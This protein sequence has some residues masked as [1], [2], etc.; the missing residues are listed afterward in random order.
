MFYQKLLALRHS[1]TAL[2]D[3]DYIALNENDP[4]VM[5]YMRGYKDQVVLVV[6]N[7]SAEPQTA[8]FNLSAQGVSS[9]KAATLLTTLS[10]LSSEADIDQIKLEPFSVYIGQVTATSK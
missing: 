3:G 5:S 9:H 1:N 10:G 7:M 4:N 8:S 6:L 2:L